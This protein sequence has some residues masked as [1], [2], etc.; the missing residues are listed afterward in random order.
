[1]MTLRSGLVGKNDQGAETP[2]VL[3]ESETTRPSG[4]PSAWVVWAAGVVFLLGTLMHVPALARRA[5]APANGEIACT[6]V[7]S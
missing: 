2:R 4:P 7:P 5:P 1:V 6:G 3:R